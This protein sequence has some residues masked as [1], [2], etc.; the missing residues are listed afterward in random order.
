MAEYTTITVEPLTPAI[1]ALVEGVHGGDPLDLRLPF[2][3]QRRAEVRDALMRHLVLFFRDRDLSGQEQL[4]LASQFGTPVSA[5][6]NPGD[7]DE[8]LFVTLEDSADDPPKSDR[9]HTDVPF[10]ATPPDVAV[11]SMRAAPPV[12]GDTLWS[13]LYAAYDAVSPTLRDRLA[14]LDLDLDLGTSAA[15]IRDLYG[16]AYYAEVMAR[17][18]GARH[19]LVRVHPVTGRPALYL[20][21]S[22]MRGIAGMHPHESAALL[23]HLQSLLDDPNRQCRWRWRQHD[24]AIWDERCTNHR[25]LSD[26]YPRYR[27][28]RRCLAGRGVPAG[29]GR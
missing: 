21:G 19:P 1:G 10:V 29:V 26:H 22:F 11:L 14:A 25:G 2:G 12:G 15:T 3:D 28:I 13:S 4:V 18:E 8:L 17:F 6:V 7:G 23:G 20:C 5:S 24:V 27:M 16:E 9:W